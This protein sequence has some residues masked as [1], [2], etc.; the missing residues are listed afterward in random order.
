[1]IFL[2]IGIL[3]ASPWEAAAYIADRGRFLSCFYW[4][5]AGKL[6]LGKKEE[7]NPEGE[8]IE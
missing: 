7:N 4:N 1:V 2:L 3:S 8:D 6:V 5:G